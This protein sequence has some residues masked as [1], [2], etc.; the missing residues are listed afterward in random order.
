MLIRASG[1]LRFG[2]AII[3]FKL[4]DDPAQ[5][6]GRTPLLSGCLARRLDEETKQLRVCNR[7]ESTE[8]IDQSCSRI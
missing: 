5:V 2:W 8:T 1:P 3:F 6:Q 7:S 4:K